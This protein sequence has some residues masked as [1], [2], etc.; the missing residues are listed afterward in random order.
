MTTLTQTKWLTKVDVSRRTP[1][2]KTA[3]KNYI[4]QTLVTTNYQIVPTILAEFPTR[5]HSEHDT[6]H[7][8]YQGVEL[9][10]IVVA[11]HKIVTL[12]NNCHLLTTVNSRIILKKELTDEFSSFPV[13]SNEVSS[14]NFKFLTTVS[15]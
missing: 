14:L 13:I 11:Q 7:Y 1:Y 12:V 6:D 10:C 8:L 2:K 3:V 4:K 5:W 15:S 9:V